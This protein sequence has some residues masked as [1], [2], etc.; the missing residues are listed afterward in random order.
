MNSINYEKSIVKI[1]VQQLEIDLNHPLNL[2]SKNESTG[3]GFFIDDNV[4]LTCYHVVNNALDIIVDIYINELDKK[5]IKAKIKHIFPDDDLAIIE[6]LEF[7]TNYNCIKLNFSI[8]TDTHSNTEV[9]TIGYP[10]DTNNIKINRGI[11]S[12]FQDSMIQTDST[13]NPGNS[14]GPLIINN[15]VIGVN[16]SKYMEASNTGFAI[17][18]F[19]FLIF[20]I[21][22]KNKLKFINKKPKLLI[23]YQEIKQGYDKFNL[24]LTINYGVIITKIA[25]L[26]ILNTTN[27]KINDILLKINNNKINNNG[28]IKFSFYPEKINLYEI[29]LWFTENDELE[30]TY[31]S[32]NTKLIHTEKIVLKCINTHLINYYY[33]ENSQPYYYNNQG[34]IF[35]IITNYHLENLNNLNLTINQKVNI[36]SRVNDIDCK[37]TIYLADIDYK[38][39][40][41]TEYPIGEI[42]SEIDNIKIDNLNIFLNI[43]KTKIKKF[44]TINNNMY[45]I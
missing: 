29:N 6:L 42:I 34:L 27:I 4:I 26:S 10:L 23:E 24:P 43:M 2:F 9:N 19:R 18:I 41:F 30:L 17:P 28:N 5:K 14:G 31:Y 45:F 25:K 7:S 12:G 36:I 32:N 3:T 21:L 22:K 8:I 11:I 37:F 16:Q 20:W 13:L 35:S 33:D 38:V 39:L 1:T 40:N 44:K 15:K